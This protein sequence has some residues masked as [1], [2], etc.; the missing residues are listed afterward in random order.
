MKNFSTLIVTLIITFI[1]TLFS[2][3]L[4]AAD[5][6]TNEFHV[7]G[8]FDS[9]INGFTRIALIFNDSDYAALLYVVVFLSIL[10][11]TAIAL[12]KEALGMGNSKQTFSMFIIPLFGATLFKI[13]MLPTSTMHIYDATHNRYQTVSS[14]PSLIA[15]IAE[16]V[17]LLERFATSAFNTS[18]TLRDK[19]A[20]GTTL[21]LYLDFSF[22]DPISNNHYLKTNISN[23]LEVCLPIGI[24]SQSYSF[25]FDT[26]Q[27]GTNDVL[28]YME[29]LKSTSN[30]MTYYSSTVKK[31]EIIDCSTGY[32]R[33]HTLLVSPAT[34]ADHIESV[35]QKSGFDTS[36]AAALTLC[37]TRIDEISD[38]V[39]DASVNISVER[40]AASQTIANALYELMADSKGS[41]IAAI[42]NKRQMTEGMGNIIVAEG[43]LPVMR[44]NTMLIKLSLTPFFGLMFL[45]TMLLKSLADVRV[46]AIKKRSPS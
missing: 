43:W 5:S 21:Q 15:Y 4:L 32:T 8:S 34:F 22:N 23:F 33:I 27:T 6:F 40:L 20:N 30:Y 46:G 38:L 35:C 42:G 9:V 36:T 1:V 44:Y 39:L 25:D 16:G 24:A 37:K 29:N 13:M 28:A 41:A 18:T 2:P 7:Y 14:V 45:T 17:N 10:A 11:G 3:A 12:G 31:G 19:H 26:F